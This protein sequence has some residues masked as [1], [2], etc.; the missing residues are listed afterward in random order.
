MKFRSVAGLSVSEVGFGCGG[1]A[2]LMLRGSAD[3]QQRIVARAL[4]LGINYFD[5]APDYGNGLAEENLG[6]V[7]QALKAHPLVVTKVEVRAADV[8][9]I[10]GHV[11]RSTEASL[12]R[13]GVEAVDILQIHNGPAQSPPALQ[14]SSYTQLGMN[15]YLGAGGALDGLQRVLRDGKARRIGFVCRGNDG[16]EVRQLI[17]LGLFHMI[18]VPYTLLNPSAGMKTPE[19]LRVERDFGDVISYARAM[20]VGCAVYSPLAGGFLTDHRV[21]GG[22]RHALAQRR[23]AV[24]AL[25]EKSLA[26]AK[27]LGFLNQPGK[28]T[29]AQAA[30]RFILAHPGVSSVLSG[31]SDLGQMEEILPAALA[32]PLDAAAMAAIERC[33]QDNFYL[34]D[35][36]IHLS[37]T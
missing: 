11:M 13:L 17:D 7:L 5:N 14:G 8:G 26:R 9:D 16:A 32:G 1:N 4:D 33:W 36:K 6:K 30:Y 18:N 3:D 20:G 34:N 23:E 10:A 12:T 28:H 37:R 22:E 31:F 25:V 21:G 19:G 35:A 24:A 15:Y 29:L 27:S 2:G